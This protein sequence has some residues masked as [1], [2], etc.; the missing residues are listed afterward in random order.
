MSEMVISKI[1]EEKSKINNCNTM[2]Y[3]IKCER[4]FLEPIIGYRYKCSICN[5]YNLCEKCEENNASSN[6]HPHN[7]IKIRNAENSTVYMANKLNDK[8]NIN[9]NNIINNNINYNNNGMK[10]LGLDSNNGIIYSYECL[11]SKLTISIYEG[12]DNASLPIIL[13][14]NGNQP[15][16]KNVSMLKFDARISQVKGLDVVLKEQMPGQQK[17]Y[18][19]QF[20]GLKNCKVGKYIV[21]YKFTINGNEYGS[22]LDTYIIVKKRVID[23]KNRQKMDL[24]RNKYGIPSNLIDDNKLIEILEKYNYNFEN[25]YSEIYN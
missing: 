16:V 17:S 1:I 11:V 5:D 18:E 22:N 7:F 23:E 15:W 2:H 14:N 12:M 13:K 4:C 19:I 21:R 10:E 25:A 3:G 8:K 9:N 20:Q 6:L 24:F